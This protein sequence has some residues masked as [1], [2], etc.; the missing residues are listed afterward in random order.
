MEG[1]LKELAKLEA[2][3]SDAANGKRK[4]PSVN[5]SLDSLL[6]S[7]REVKDRLQAG[8]AS[9]ET[10]VLLAKTVDARRKEIDDRQKEVYNSLA[11]YG[12]ALDKVRCSSRRASAEQ[13]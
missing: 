5:D 12:K 4:A 13:E 3:T 8:S 10:L 2:L 11:R 6:D 1:P 9:D 7:L